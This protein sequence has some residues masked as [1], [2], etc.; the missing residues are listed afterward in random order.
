MHV[1]FVT[2]ELASSNNS[3][4]G[5]ANFT[6][7]FAH[8]FKEKGNKVSIILASTKGV[9]INVDRRGDYD[10][11]DIT[12][13]SCILLSVLAM[14]VEHLVFLSLSRFLISLF[15]KYKQHG[16]MLILRRIIDV[17]FQLVNDQILN[18][19]KTLNKKLQWLRLHD[20]N[21]EYTQMV[22]KYSVKQLVEKELGSGY[23]IP[24]LRVLESFDDIE[25]IDLPGQFA[26]KCK[27]RAY[28]FSKEIC[29]VLDH[30]ER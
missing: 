17:K 26:L 3:S 20:H 14:N 23:M 27:H 19:S 22:D 29:T 13:R 8:I 11:L 28:N 12:T 6:A 5:L 2:N 21:P 10:G 1:V 30:E 4:G 7:N 18:N 24:T 16:F 15:L 9:N 25:F